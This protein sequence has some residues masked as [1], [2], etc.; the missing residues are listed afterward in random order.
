MIEEVVAPVDQTGFD[1]VVESTELP[2]L[3]VTVAVGAAGT[4]VVVT[5]TDAHVIAVSFTQPVPSSPLTK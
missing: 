4:G 1:P 2:Q 5:E 3:F